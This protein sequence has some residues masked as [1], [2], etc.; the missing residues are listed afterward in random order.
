MHLTFLI[1][2]EVHARWQ[3]P[4]L[5]L[6]V[7]LQRAP[8]MRAVTQLFPTWVQGPGGQVMRNLAVVALAAGGVDTLAGATTL[9]ATPDSPATAT[10]GTS[11]SAGFAV[12]NAPLIT[13][14][15][16]IF[17]LP[18]GL[19]VPNSTG[20]SVL[21]LN[22]S[23][24]TITGTPTQAGIYDV[25]ITG[26]EFLN[27]SG[28]SANFTYTIEVVGALTAPSISSHP[29]SQTITQGQS[30]TFSVSASGTEPFAY[31]WRHNGGDI[32]GANSSSFHISSVNTG[33]AG[34]YTVLVSNTAG[35][36]LSN[37]ATL[38]VNVPAVAPTIITQ[39]VS[40]TVNA[41]QSTA[42]TVGASGTAPFSYQWRRNGNDIAGANADLYQIVS[43]NSSHAGEYT[44]LVS[45]AAG[46][47]L[48][49]GATLTVNVPPAVTTHPASQTIT[50]GQSVTFT[51]GV[52]GTTPFSYQWRRNGSDIAGA[53]AASYQI[54]SVNSSHAG[55]YTVLVSNVAGSAFSNG[56]TLTVNVPPA[57][58]THPASQT[59]TAGQSVTFTV[60]ASGTTPFSYQWQIDGEDI[61]G[62]NGSSYQIATV[63]AAHAGSYRVNVSNSVGSALSN[64]A[65][66]TVNRLAQT[67]SF[68]GPADQGYT[69]TPIA[70]SATATSS[71]P[72]VFSLLGGPATLEGNQLRLTGA[73][74]VTVRA[75]Q[76]GN[77]IFAAA[78][79]VDRA[80][81]VTANLALW[82]DG[83]FT[84]TEIADPDVS[85]PLTDP[86]G[87]GLSNL[88]EYA[89]G[90]DPR[91]VSTFAPGV[92]ATNDD[93][94]FTYTRPALRPDLVYSVEVSTDLTGWTADPVT[95]QRTAQLESTEEWRAAVPRSAGPRLF[96]RL[97]VTRQ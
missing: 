24:G 54:A 6:A 15:Y 84:P 76:A 14:S 79:V 61:A 72:V 86:D 39:P 42:F 64:P 45:N 85:G 46:S 53:N 62:A 90:L 11:F 68:T 48:S 88:V 97:R 87:D 83:H 21:I 74:T 19:T 27:A 29:S 25:S 9:A 75:A 81:S 10:L 93:W 26:W 67:I 36:A 43:V 12:V 55:E 63:T 96:F 2:N 4:V 44:V 49:N 77:D 95:H 7:L 78:P 91:S 1:R 40:Q 35:S 80:F 69:R 47:A 59:I 23:S 16:S 22:Q 33:H 38:T 41:G 52:S 3:F 65:V 71:L 20:S 82:A 51:V 34:E 8:A 17:G 94:L 37:G 50:A 5:V 13:R 66:L 60:G 32:S 89:L 28:R 58:T 57:V 70:L 56:A 92:A 30:V 31:Q 18:P 73:G